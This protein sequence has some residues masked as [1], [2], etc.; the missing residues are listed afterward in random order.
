MRDRIDPTLDFLS[1]ILA[2]GTDRSS[3]SISRSWHQFGF[4]Q[5]A[6]STSRASLI[7]VT[8][9]GPTASRRRVLSE[10]GAAACPLGRARSQ[11]VHKDLHADIRRNSWSDGTIV[12]TEALP[13]QCHVLQHC[14]SLTAKVNALSENAG[15]E[16]ST[17]H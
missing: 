9:T 8:S 17:S 7:S 16:A 15:E 13:F 10:A 11:K 5:S 3:R 12:W 4:S 6:L 1:K 14:G 2:E